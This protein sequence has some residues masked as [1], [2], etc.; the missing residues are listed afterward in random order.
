MKSEKNIIIR[1]LSECDIRHDL[2]GKQLAKQKGGL[3]QLFEREMLKR[4][5]SSLH[6]CSGVCVHLSLFLSLL[7]FSIL[8]VLF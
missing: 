2:N 1:L 6:C 5:H 3:H 7:F 8:F 4:L